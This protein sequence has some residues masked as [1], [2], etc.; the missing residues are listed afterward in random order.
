MG[1]FLV[2]SLLVVGMN[3]AY[4]VAVDYLGDASC[5]ASAA[6][7]FPSVMRRIPLPSLCQPAFAPFGS[8]HYRQS[9]EDSTV[10]EE[11]FFFG[12]DC[13]G[14]IGNV[15]SSPTPKVS[16]PFPG[17]LF[18]FYHLVYQCAVGRRFSSQ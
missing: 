12:S 17:L 2:F 4:M 8:R 15:V 10:L 3:A 11:V 18:I 6:G 5:G 7:N 16:K 14:R 9:P 13:S 1:F